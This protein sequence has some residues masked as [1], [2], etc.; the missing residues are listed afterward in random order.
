M[1]KSKK[2]VKISEIAIIPITPT[3]KGIVAFCNFIIDNSYKV[4]DVA[5]STDLTNKSFRLIYP[6]KQIPPKNQTIQIFYPINKIVAD[7]IQTQVIKKYQS[8]FERKEE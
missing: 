5:I 2:T 8:L 3:P 1:T 7:K 6:L 4:C